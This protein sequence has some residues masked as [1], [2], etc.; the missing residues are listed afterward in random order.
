MTHLA[1]ALLSGREPD[2]V[3]GGWL[4]DFVRGTPDPAL[5][6]GVRDGIVLHRAIDTYTDAH[7]DV[8]AARALFDAPF[9]RYAGILVD[10]WFDHLLARDFARWSDTPLDV[11]G[12]DQLELLQRHHDRLPGELQRFM[13]YMRQHGLPAAYTDRYAISRAFAG[14][15]SRFRHENP[16]ADGMRAI[17]PIEGALSEHFASFFPSLLAFA[18]KRRDAANLRDVALPIQPG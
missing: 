16:L 5:P 1:H 12:S 11:F 8:V 10:V 4:G 2:V 17:E 9:R 18:A 15:A 3:L 14:I 13:R 6:A 7:A